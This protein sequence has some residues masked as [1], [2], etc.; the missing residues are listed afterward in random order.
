MLSSRLQYAKTLKTLCNKNCC[1]IVHKK[2]FLHSK[3]DPMNRIANFF[4]GAVI[5]ILLI[6]SLTY[7]QTDTKEMLQTNQTENVTESLKKDVRILCWIMTSPENHGKK[8]IHVKNTWLQR[9]NKV[10][11]VSSLSNGNVYIYKYHFL[12]CLTLVLKLKIAPLRLFS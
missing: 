1:K 12:F 4:L 6:S 2:H 8:A 5:S 3:I 7:L 10:L 11:F 9:C